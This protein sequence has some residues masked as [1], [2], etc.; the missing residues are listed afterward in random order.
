M[1]AEVSVSVAAVALLVGCAFDPAGLAG[2]PRSDGGGP[3]IDGASTVDAAE[4]G[5]PPG[6][7]LV[8][9]YRFEGDAD[10]DTSYANHATWSNVTFV[11]GRDG[12]GT[13]IAFSAT[14][15][16]IAA[17]TAS[18]DVTAAMTVEGWLRID[19]LP[20]I[21]ARMG[22]LDNN[23][24]YGLFL[25]PNG[26]IRCAV[27]TTTAIGLVVF[28][29]AWTHVACTYDGARVQLYQDGVAGAFVAA[30]GAVP[31]AGVDGLALGQNLPDPPAD[32]LAGALDDVRI[33]RIALSA[34][35]VCASA[36]TCP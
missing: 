26:Q 30:S 14:A 24:Q 28:V 35:E 6:D 20:A 25:A 17:D 15:S 9:C 1:H 27:G 31:T 16:V 12:R 22:V 7:D 33:W 21:N 8:A 11:P 3:G 13:A 5:C 32:H 29:G 19:A 34:A 23:G 4:P 10:D 2:G 18:L 36:G